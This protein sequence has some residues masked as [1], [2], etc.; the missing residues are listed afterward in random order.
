MKTK[1]E[2]FEKA[3][4][5]STKQLIDMFVNEDKQ[6]TFKG[7]QFAH[8]VYFTDE[9]GSRTLNKQ[10]A[11]QKL[12]RTCITV[13]SSYQDR[14][15]RDLEKRGEEGN[16]TSQSQSGQTPINKYVSQ[17][18][19][20]QKY[21]LKAVVEYFNTPDTIY[22]ENNKVR[23]FKDNL[24][25]INS[26]LF[27]PSYFT[28]STTSGRGNMSEEKDFSFFTVGFDKIYSLRIKGILY[29]VEK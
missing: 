10:K 22:Y 29:K 24:D 8:I 5:I 26:D 9:S 27:M 3:V 19:K 18:D 23:R 28:P 15:N 12:V 4:V 17:S 6:S 2:K 21:N 1:R 14:I 25:K 20:S 7:C 16:F 13:G 11:L